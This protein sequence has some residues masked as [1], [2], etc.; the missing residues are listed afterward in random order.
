[1]SSTSLHKDAAEAELQ[2]FLKDREGINALS[3]YTRRFQE[4]SWDQHYLDVVGQYDRREEGWDSL[5]QVTAF[6]LVHHLLMN[7]NVA[8]AEVGTRGKRP[9]SDACREGNA[10]ALARVP[11]PFAAEVDMEQYCGPQD[12]VLSWT[13]PIEVAA[14]TGVPYIAPGERPSPVQVKKLIP[15]GSVPLEIGTTNASSTLWHL[16]HDGGVAR[17]PYGHDTIRLWVVVRPY[18]PWALWI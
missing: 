3:V 7:G 10:S 14:S 9:Q 1:M 5:A 15:P 4:G 17:W 16:R 11:R 18:E 6:M 12:G 13:T 2:T 8:E